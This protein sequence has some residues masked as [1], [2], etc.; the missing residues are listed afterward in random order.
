MT[1]S[2][3]HIAVTGASGF[4]GRNTLLPLAQLGFEVHA[5]TRKENPS[6]ELLKGLGA[7]DSLSKP[8]SKS[9]FTREDKPRLGA[10]HW[11]T[12]ELSNTKQVRHWLESHKPSHFL[13]LAWNVKHGKYWENAHN[14]DDLAMSL[15]L[16]RNF[17]EAGGKRF[18]G[19]GTC[20]EYDWTQDSAESDLVFFDEIK[21]LI[22]PSTLY[23]A[24]K[25][26]AFLTGTQFSKSRGIEF[27]WGR[28]FNLFGPGEDQARIIP[29][30]VRAHLFGTEL[31]CSQGTQI[32]DFLPASE[33][34]SALASLAGSTVVGPVNIAS[35][36]GH[37]LRSLSDRIA[38]YIACGPAAIR[39]GAFHDSGPNRL[40][41]NVNRLRNEVGWSPKTQ[42]V[43]ALAQLVE[44]CRSHR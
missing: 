4:I 43:E 36:E 27:A 15:D 40:V 10:I 31:N 7:I 8:S 26:S 14:L 1:Q 37:S 5:L 39:F 20:A 29:A 25:A 19:V 42:L 13:H 34:G 28:I 16:L 24:A 44:W 41:A 3:G 30:L 38:E 6:H 22:K 17:A 18:V 33:V 23:G 2:L 35:G 11:H 9:A 12:L 21:S 32:R